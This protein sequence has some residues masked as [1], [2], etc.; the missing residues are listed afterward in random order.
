MC[1]RCNKTRAEPRAAL[2]PQ[3]HTVTGRTEIGYPT[4]KD[5]AQTPDDMARGC[6][7]IRWMGS[8]SMIPPHGAM[9]K[10]HAGRWSRPANPLQLKLLLSTQGAI[11]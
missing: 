2:L 10:F 3:L 4:A 6:G 1:G 7:N 11:D 5:L 9:K 8:G